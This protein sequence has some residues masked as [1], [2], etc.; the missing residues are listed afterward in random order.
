MQNNYADDLLRLA[1]RLYYVDGLGQQEVAKFTKVSQAKVSRLL[2]MAR[3]RGIVRISVADYE[4]RQRELETQLRALLGLQLAVVI[5]TA[6]GL[7]GDDLRRTVGHFAAPAVESVLQPRDLVALAG[8]R[9]IHDL[10]HHFPGN[11]QCALTVIQAMGSVD[12]N[13]SA[14]DAQEVGREMIQRLGGSLLALNTPAFIP[15]RRTRDALLKLE[16]IRVV[17]E[18]LDKAQAALLGVGTLD[19][20][21]FVARGVL[22]PS[23][24]AELREAGAVGEICGRFFDAKGQECATSWRDR[25]IGIRIEQL[26]RIPQSIGVVAGSDRTQALLAAVK[27]GLLKSLVIDEAGAASL[28]AAARASG[29]ALQAKRKKEK[30]K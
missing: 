20:S 9:T 18:H 12:S 23:A 13:V 22:K 6:A 29:E 4:P 11:K 25:V 17:H 7:E 21:V 10:V 19:N 24:Q 14:V 8:G 28:I 5:K 26:R 27:G 15:D 2:A 3:E 30:S 1:A 16:Q